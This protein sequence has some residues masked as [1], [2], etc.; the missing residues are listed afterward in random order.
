M[1]PPHNVIILFETSVEC[2]NINKIIVFIL[3]YGSNTNL[4]FGFLELFR[5]NWQL[6]LAGVFLDKFLN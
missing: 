4:M 2:H 5:R 3:P 6:K 1:M